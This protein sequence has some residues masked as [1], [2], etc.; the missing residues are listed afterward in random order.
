MIARLFFIGTF[1]FSIRP[2][3]QYGSVLKAHKAH[4][5]V[6]LGGDAKGSDGND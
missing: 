3:L 6:G 1:V 4:Y 5:V 2:A